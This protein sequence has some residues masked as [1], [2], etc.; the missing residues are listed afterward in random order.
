MP[1]VKSGKGVLNE[2]NEI[3]QLL[4]NCSSGCSA[5]SRDDRQ[6]PK[7]ESWLR[8]TAIQSGKQPSYGKRVQL[9]PDG[10][11]DPELHLNRALELVHPFDSFDSLKRDHQEALD[12]MTSLRMSLPKHR[13]KTL[14]EIKQLSECSD[15]CDKQSIHEKFASVSALKLGRKPW[16]A[17]MEVLQDRYGIEDTSVPSLCLTGMPIVGKALSS[18]FLLQHDVPAAISVRELLS[19]SKKHRATMMSRVVR[20]AESSG[21]QTSAAIWGKTIK[22]VS[23]GSMAGPF[24]L[25][26]IQSRHGSFFNVVP[27]FGLEQGLDE[28]G[29]PKFRRIDDHSACLNNSAAHR[30]QKIEMANVDYLAIMIRSLQ[31]TF[32]EGACVGTED[33]KGA[34]R[35]IPLPD[36]QVSISITAVYDPASKQ[37]KLF[38]IYGQPFGAGHAV[39]NFYRVAEWL[40]RLLVRALHL[41]IDHFFDDFFYTCRPAEERLAL[42]CVWEVFRLIGFDIDG[43]KSH[44]PA[45]LCHVLGVAIN[46]QAL[47]VERYFLVEAKPSRKSNFCKMVRTVLSQGELTPCL[48]GSIVGKFGFLCSS[49]FGKVGRCCTK[50]V[51]DRQYS[52]SPPFSIDSNLR[53]SLQLMAEFVNLSPPRKVQ[54]SNDKPRP[55]L[56]TD[57]SDVPDRQGGRFVL[58]AVLLYGASR[59][60]MEYTSLVLPPDL[61]A[62]WTHRKSYM[63]QLELLAGPLA[64]ATWPAVLRDTK[65]FH[66]VDNDSAAAC[67]VKGYSPQVD[68]SPLVGDY[69]L[70]AAA[71]GLDVYIDRVES[72]SNLADGPSRLDYQMVHSLGGKYVPPPPGFSI[73]TLDSFSKL[74]WARHL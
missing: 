42:F 71:A 10:L 50:S 18:P 61:V 14:G 33:M 3:A 43:K 56:Y 1:L 46:T 69:W 26:E 4:D 11:N 62:T 25:E 68:S 73:P 57:A 53:V 47:A 38:E 60:R 2:L 51:R 63:G 15:V 39:P 34:Y 22:E 52:V 6:D 40:S 70:K 65:L 7:T 17:L 28:S 44:P 9:I 49:L 59:E 27:S 8:Q 45:E 32:K 31:E 72:K 66:F 24:T 41:L 16:T 5:P 58:G 21:E 13:L 12:Y 23:E 67:L 29:K 74:D 36:A 30:A 35:Q 20:M 48:A 55:I 54:M 37:A 64:L 19:L